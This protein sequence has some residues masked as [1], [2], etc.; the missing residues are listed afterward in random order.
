MYTLQLNTSRI[1][2]NSKKK[3]S[4]SMS[5]KSCCISLCRYMSLILHQRHMMLTLKT[6]RNPIS[7]N[8]TSMPYL[9]FNALE[10]I[11]SISFLEMNHIIQNYNFDLSKIIIINRC[12]PIIHTK[13]IVC[14]L[15][16]K[17]SRR[18][19]SFYITSSFPVFQC[20]TLQPSCSE[21]DWILYRR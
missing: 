4:K 1:H 19:S 16:R 8:H 20:V 3:R 18:V 7:Q 13:F 17:K 12:A 14:S 11:Q 15:F 9:S 6:H 21:L 10:G 2:P 5:I